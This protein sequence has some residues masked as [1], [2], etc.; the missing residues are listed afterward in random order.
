M[1]NQWLELYWLQKADKKYWA[2][3][4]QFL[5]MEGAVVGYFVCFSIVVFYS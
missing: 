5:S 4:S 3:L 1:L 2:K